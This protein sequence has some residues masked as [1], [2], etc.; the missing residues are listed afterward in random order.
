MTDRSVFH[1]QAQH[2]DVWFE[3]NAHAYASEVKAL[4]T[5]IPNLGAG[6]EVGVG[7]GR[8]AVPLGIRMGVEPARAM[9]V[10][11]RQR[12]ITVYEAR[13]EALPFSD[14]SF[15]FVMIVTTLCFLDDPV[16]AIRE[17]KR[18]LMPGGRIVI[19]MIDRETPFGKAYERRKQKSAFY[20][21]AHFHS[22]MQVIAWLQTVGFTA[23]RTCQTLFA[24]LEEMTAVDPVKEGHGQ[25][26]FAVI[27]GYKEG[28]M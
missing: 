21:L 8:F 11:A 24:F 7:T 17:A 9:A 18:V 22:V 2:Y 14:A 20:R 26:G 1:R 15:D 25:G 12:G 27:T 4:R 23:I 16:Q 13:A 5:F 10:I 6:L 3:R 28:T 19:G